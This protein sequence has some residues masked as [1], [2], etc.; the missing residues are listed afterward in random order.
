[1]LSPGFRRL[2]SINYQAV[3][4]RR[5][6][7]F[8]RASKVYQRS[9]ALL[10]DGELLRAEEVPAA[11][12]AAHTSLNLALTEKALGNLASARKVFEKGCELVQAHVLGD[13][14]AW[15]DS[16][17]NLCWRG[18][19]MPGDQ[20]R[21]EVQD[22]LCWLATLLTAWALLET[23]RGRKTIGR[24]L[25]SRAA[26]FDDRKAPVLKWQALGAQR[27]PGPR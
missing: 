27:V 24:R 18:D 16:Q 2:A 22:A 23:Q 13:Y 26:G 6:K 7:K 4:L 19:K 10:E 1:V 15:I 12:A 5:D 21:S 3:Q 25:A 20:E 11:V 14:G 8:G 9:L 17:Q